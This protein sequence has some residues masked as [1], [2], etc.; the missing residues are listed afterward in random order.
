MASERREGNSQLRRAAT[1]PLRSWLCVDHCV[2]S[3][4]DF[5]LSRFAALV[6]FSDMLS[7]I[8]ALVATD[9]QNHRKEPIFANT[10]CSGFY[11]KI[12]KIVHRGMRDAI[13]LTYS[14]RSVSQPIG[15]L[16]RTETSRWSWFAPE[17][18]PGCLPRCS[19]HRLAPRPEREEGLA[20]RGAS[21]NR[22]VKRFPESPSRPSPQSPLA[23]TQKPFDPLADFL[24]L[25][26]SFRCFYPSEKHVCF[27]QLRD[28]FRRT[29]IK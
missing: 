24:F 10:Y 1:A 19:P 5:S 20:S 2:P 26:L 11:G 6:G 28:R 16:K 21:A 3:A 7:K 14:Y 4:S 8:P 9:P 22:R 25:S 12:Q 15:G 17:T 13:I 29:S 27:A 23:Q 18:R